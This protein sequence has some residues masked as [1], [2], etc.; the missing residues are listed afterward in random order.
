MLSPRRDLVLRGPQAIGP[1]CDMSSSSHMSP[2]A[3]VEDEAPTSRKCSVDGGNGWD[4]LGSKFQRAKVGFSA[5]APMPC[6]AAPCTDLRPQDAHGTGQNVRVM[7]AGA[8]F[9]AREHSIETK[10]GFLL[11]KVGD[12]IQTPT[13]SGGGEATNHDGD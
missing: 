3:L 12:Q 7:S 10:E 13:K 4:S 11:K 2:G 1:L 6:G 9:S 8:S 5:G